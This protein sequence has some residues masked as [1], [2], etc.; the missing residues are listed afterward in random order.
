ME[1]VKE[2]QTL[3]TTKVVYNSFPDRTARE[4]LGGKLNNPGSLKSGDYLRV[5]SIGADGTVVLEGADG[6]GGGGSGQNVELDTTLTVAGKAADAKA[7]GDAL[8][9]VGKPT[10]EQVST[11]VNAYLAEHPVDGSMSAQARE[12]LLVILQNAHFDNDQSANIEALATALGEAGLP[13]SDIESWDLVWDYTNGVAAGNSGWQTMVDNW[14]SFTVD[15]DSENGQTI[16]DAK[17]DNNNGLYYGGLL[18]LIPTAERAVME[19]VVN[20]SD[21]GTGDGGYKGK[22]VLCLSN[23]TSGGTLHLRSD[24]LALNNE[25]VYEYGVPVGTD[26]TLRLEYD[27]AA[28]VTIYFNNI[29]VGA[30]T[31]VVADAN[32]TGH[33]TSM[34]KNCVYQSVSGS[35]CIKSIKYRG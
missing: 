7:V 28:G 4:Q 16:T 10:D 31:S 12:L 15:F 14:K 24:G 5:Q 18:C 13:D 29:K 11:A 20:V 8:K 22:F 25:L 35:V 9:S 30:T 6:T 19:C 1:E 26:H 23:G 3:A 34:N 33:K 27:S 32:A 21:F 2:L 17:P